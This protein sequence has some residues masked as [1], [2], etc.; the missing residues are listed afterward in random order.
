MDTNI[1]ILEIQWI[2]Y[3][4]MNFLLNEYLAGYKYKKYYPVDI[5][6]YPL[7]SLYIISIYKINALIHLFFFYNDKMMINIEYSYVFIPFTLCF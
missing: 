3:E 5:H 7:W 4:Y 2:K 6:W 1:D